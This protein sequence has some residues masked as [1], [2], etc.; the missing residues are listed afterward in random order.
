[1]ETT[2]TTRTKRGEAR[3]HRAGKWSLGICR[4]VSTLVAG[5]AYD[6]ESRPNNLEVLMI[7]RIFRARPKPG[8]ADELA[9]LIE[10]VSIPF[11]DRQPGLLARYHGRGIGSTRGEVFLLFVWG[12]L[13]AVKKQTRGH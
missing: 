2:E 11:V 6:R 13:V 1:M 4:L 3:H 8:M 7:I 5:S 9:H 10:E 12:G